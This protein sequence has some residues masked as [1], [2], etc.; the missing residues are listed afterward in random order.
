ME[1]EYSQ[2]VRGKVYAY[3]FSSFEKSIIAK[4]LATELKK[5]PKKI[6]KVED[7]PNNEGQLDYIEK[8]R[9]LKY[10]AEDIEEIIKAFS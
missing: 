6:Q 2:E 9:E 4:A 3:R 5:Y 7:D 8:I 10:E 1:I